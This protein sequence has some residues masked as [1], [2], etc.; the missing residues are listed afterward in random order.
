MRTDSPGAEISEIN[1]TPFVDIVLVLLV[2]FMATATLIAEN[3]LNIEV[4]K[5]SASTDKPEEKEI[6]T[7]FITKEGKTFIG[8]KEIVAEQIEGEI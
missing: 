4:P 6:G 1:M 7:L 3:K 5:A 8:E 2:I